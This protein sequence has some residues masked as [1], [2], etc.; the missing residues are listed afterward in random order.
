MKKNVIKLKNLWSCVKGTSFYLTNNLSAFELSLR[1]T[2]YKNI[3]SNIDPTLWSNIGSNLYS[4]FDD[5]LERSLASSI[6][7]NINESRMKR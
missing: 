2:L 3:G 6:F 1:P 4:N 5:S 7:S